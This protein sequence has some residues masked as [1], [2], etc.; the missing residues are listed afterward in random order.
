MSATAWFEHSIQVQPQDTDYAGVVWHGAYIRWMEAGR[1]S[2][3][4]QVGVEF[5][6]LVQLGCDLPVVEL[7]IHYHHPLRM[8]EVAVVRSRLASRSKIRLYWEQ[9]IQAPETQNPYI[10]AQVTLVFVDR[11]RGRVLRKLPPMA[12]MACE[13]L[14]APRIDS[15]DHS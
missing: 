13:K 8:G 6:D 15:L 3:L 2:A 11:I 1:I 9:W 4:R 12:K 5:T 7:S 14:A 10:T